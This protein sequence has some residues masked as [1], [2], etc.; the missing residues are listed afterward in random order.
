MYKAVFLDIGGVI[1][2]IDWNRPFAY[3]GIHD[4]RERQEVLTRVQGAETFRLYER[5]EL[6]T[7]EFLETFN[8]L[9]GLRHPN[10]FWQEAW[11]SLII[12]ELEGVGEIF[13]LL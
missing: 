7:K 5:G 3:A 12:G 2:K 1:L 10:Q 6:T 8:E 11:Q 9:T 13:D 4:A